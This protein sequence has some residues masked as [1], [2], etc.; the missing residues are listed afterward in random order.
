[1]LFTKVKPIE[2]KEGEP[3][4]L[5]LEF[6]LDASPSATTLEETPELPDID[7]ADGSLLDTLAVLSFMYPSYDVLKHLQ[8]HRQGHAAVSGRPPEC[9]F[10]FGQMSLVGHITDS[11]ISHRIQQRRQPHPRRHQRH[12]Q[13]TV[14]ARADLAIGGAAGQWFRE[15]CRRHAGSRE[16]WGAGQDLVAGPSAESVP[17]SAE[18]QEPHTMAVTPRLPG[19]RPPVIDAPDASGTRRPTLAMRILVRPAARPVL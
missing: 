12:A 4:V 6:K 14:P 2:P 19:T 7:R 3:Q 9:T 13:R 11:G 17:V 15:L 5:S 1:M 16:R 10:I 8:D 18:A